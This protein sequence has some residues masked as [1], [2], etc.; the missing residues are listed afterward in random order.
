MPK[1][2]FRLGPAAICIQGSGE[3]FGAIA[4]NFSSFEPAED[5]AHIDLRFTI[6]ELGDRH[7][8]WKEESDGEGADSANRQEIRVKGFTLR[9]DEVQPGPASTIE[10]E[11][12]PWQTRKRR[13]LSILPVPLQRFANMRYASSIELQSLD[14]LFHVYLWLTQMALLQHGATYI[15]ASA[16]YSES[17]R[18]TLLI[19]GWGGVGKTSLT[20]YAYSGAPGDWAFLSD[21]LSIIDSNGFVW[22][23]S[24]AIHYYPYNLRGFHTLSERLY[25]LLTPIDR[26]H[27]KLREKLF[28]SSGVVRRIDPHALWRVSASSQHL[29]RALFLERWPDSKPQCRAMA[30]EDFSERSLHILLFELKTILTPIII[31]H[32]TT[33]K[34]LKAIIPTIGTFIT[35]TESI[36]ASAFGG[37]SLVHMFVPKPWGPVEL[38]EYVFGDP[39]PPRTSPLVL[40]GDR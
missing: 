30:L 19:S 31:A 26:E 23:N 21:D 28:G 25:R 27:W 33:D 36:L 6:L 1:I 12:K 10:V 20:S 3:L 39:Y 17:L 15:H 9:I 38:G 14:F 7:T 35:D 24:L 2:T 8:A 18:K 22:P 5:A 40:Q 29:S 11:C 16:M 37:T 13:L 32:A 34:A 4:A